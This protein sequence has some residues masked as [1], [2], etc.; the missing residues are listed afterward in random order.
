MKS[1]NSNIN[2]E[3][4]SLGIEQY[5][6]EIEPE[7]IL[8]LIDRSVLL[9]MVR[10]LNYR[11]RKGA[12][13]QYATRERDEHGG[14]DWKVLACNEI[15]SSV[16]DPS[17]QHI[18]EFVYFNPFCKTL[19][20]AI[21]RG[22]CQQSDCKLAQGF[23]DSPDREASIE[24]CWLR[25][26]EPC[27]PIKIAGQTRAVLV[28]GGQIVTDS[29]HKNRIVAEL[30]KRHAQ[31]EL[32]KDAGG[33]I[34]DLKLQ[35]LIDTLETSQNWDWS[36]TD[37][38]ESILVQ[39]REV[40]DALQKIVDEMFAGRRRQ[41]NHGLM[42]RMAQ[43]LASGAYGSPETWWDNAGKLFTE[44][45]NVLGVARIIIYTRSGSSF[46]RTWTSDPAAT[47]ANRPPTRQIMGSLATDTFTK[48][49]PSNS[50]HLELLASLNLTGAPMVHLLHTDHISRDHHHFGTLIIL[51]GALTSQ[52]EDLAESF[53]HEVCLRLSIVSLMFHI[54]EKDAGFRGR[55]SEIAHSFRTPLQAL[56]C[57][58]GAALKIPSIREDSDMRERLE[59]SLDK[60]YD[61]KLDVSLLLDEARPVTTSIDLASLLL[62]IMTDLKSLAENQSRSFEKRGL[63]PDGLSVI[64][65]RSR[66]RRAFINLM[67]NALKYSFRN[68]FVSLELSRTKKG[69]ARVKIDNYGIGIPQEKLN[70]IFGMG[71]RLNVTDPNPAAR[72]GAG[73]G[74]P[75]AM[76]IIQDFGGM[77]EIASKP[78]PGKPQDP[79]NPYHNWVTEVTVTLPHK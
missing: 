67:E 24:E 39:V 72:Q 66:L 73:M 59:E 40:A 27:A 2:S 18:G 34:S 51:V 76:K 61:A 37:S 49:N 11:F 20:E 1:K 8:E 10:A 48:L 25:L 5:R 63:W 57:D 54:Q 19:A 14:S 47:A 70:E 55:V 79:R 69:D 65:D 17:T 42:A 29:E 53:C 4:F 38:V 46:E 71:V 12:S 41:A 26:L 9:E 44:M 6:N 56:I 7:S 43:G 32:Q 74:L 30:L 28:G 64:G 21:G 31:G 58:L 77:I 78:A 15:N 45:A 50:G 13:L 35:H 16:A 62:Q 75:H 36:F 22:R 68:H 23:V 52:N 33:L 60:L 3:P